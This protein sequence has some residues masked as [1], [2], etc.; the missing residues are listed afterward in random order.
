MARGK[1]KGSA[2][3]RTIC[4]LLSTWIS[5][6][7][8]EDIFW[9]SAGSGAMATSRFRS[10]KKG[11]TQGGD[12]VAVDPL[13][14]EFTKNITIEAKAGYSKMSVQDL[15]DRPESKSEFLAWIE[16]VRESMQQG[17][18]KD[19]L[20][21]WKRNRSEIMCYSRR[22]L[23]DFVQPASYSMIKY[24]IGKAVYMFPFSSFLRIK[25][26]RLLEFYERVESD[27]SQ[28]SLRTAPNVK[29]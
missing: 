16:Q 18:T 9:R 8:R 4:R 20:I 2:F 3:E 26:A 27:V 19:W 11:T 14:A 5:Q 21:L 29:K 7:Q 28:S 24:G 22:T 25:P 17:Q 6:G 23:F 10:G 15:L 1:S 13:G 12:I